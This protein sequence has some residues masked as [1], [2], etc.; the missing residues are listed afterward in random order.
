MRGFLLR[1]LDLTKRYLLWDIVWLVYNLINAC[2]IGLIG[3]SSGAQPGYVTGG[4][5]YTLY[6]VLGAI[7]WS[8]LAVV[9]ILIAETIAFE[10]WEGTLEYTMM[11]PVHRFTRLF[12][13]SAFA[14][15]YGIVRIILMLGLLVW[16]FK[17]DLS[18]A[19][20]AGALLTLVI[21]TVAMIGLGL[22]AAVLPLLSPEKGAQA[23]EIL[24]AM[25][26]LVSGVYYPITVLPAW[27]Q[28]LAFA[29]PPYWTLQA[30]RQALLEGAPTREMLPALGG[31]ALIG[32]LYVP[33]GYIV[34]S[35]GEKYAK[36]TGLLKRSG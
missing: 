7:M 30:L 2:I 20:F 21:S 27:L 9:F 31:L 1:D 5:T 13:I 11:A 36:K 4:Q 10:R 24:L 33:L 35:L 12:G 22:M 16:L 14:V 18:G 6:L 29:S 3:V 15:A 19:N 32:L 23:T 25:S 26:L 34:F 17:L 8:Y 28:P